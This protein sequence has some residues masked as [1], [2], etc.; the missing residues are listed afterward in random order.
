MTT[1]RVFVYNPNSSQ[2]MTQLIARSARDAAGSGIEIV[3]ACGPATVPPSI[4]GHHDEA[5]AVPPMLD[6]LRR[7]EADGAAAHVIACFDDPGLGAAREVTAG[8]VIGIAQAAMQVACIVA[9][10]FSV[11]TTLPRSI[12]II[13][14]LALRYGMAHA[15]RR[16]RAVDLPVLA[17]EADPAQA[18]ALLLREIRDARDHDGAEAVILGCAGMSDMCQSLSAET[19]I[20]VIDGVHAAVRLAGALA[21]GGYRT[22]K[23]GAYAWPRDKSG[24][25]DHTAAPL[26]KPAQ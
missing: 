21:A 6:A 9:S 7:A 16:V 8:P 5:M 12:P 17:L 18:R 25:L 2:A 23:T 1:L 13:E 22:A 10:R 19:G 3:A 24:D 14:D 11:V 4:E 20:P 15:L 26:R